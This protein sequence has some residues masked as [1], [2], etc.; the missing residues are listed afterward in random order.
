MGIGLVLG[1]GSAVAMTI[2]TTA[3]LRAALDQPTQSLP[4]RFVVHLDQGD[5]AVYQRTGTSSQVGPVSSKVNHAVTVRPQDV[6]VTGP[7]GQTLTAAWPSGT[8]TLTNNGEIFTAAV[9]FAAPDPGDYT[10]S[11]KGT[12]EVLV[13]ERVFT[14]MSKALPWLLGLGLGGL[15]FIAGLIALIVALSRRKNAAV[16]PGPYSLPPGS[17]TFPPPAPPAQGTHPS[18]P[19]STS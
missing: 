10:I 9:V 4:A 7:T 18:P 5:F 14:V 12:G 1:I 15:A 6:T 16:Q 11:V 17:Q 3:S 19:H 13:G 8:E 2:A